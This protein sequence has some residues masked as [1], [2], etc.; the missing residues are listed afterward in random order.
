[1]NPRWS[2]VL[3][4]FAPGCAV[5]TTT[6]DTVPSGDYAEADADSDSDSDADSD[7]DVDTT[8]PPENEDALSL[9]PPAQT[10]RYV[11]VANPDRDTVTRIAV[12]TLD[13]DT[14]PVG[15]DPEIVLTTPDFQHAVVF[16]RGDATV[17]TI[18][19]NTLEKHTVDVRDNLNQMVMSPDGA[20]VVLF[21][22]VR[23]DALDDTGHEPDGL[24][25]FNEASFV[26]VATAAHSPMAVGFN[27]KMVRFTPDAR[28]AVVVSDA[29]LAKIELRREVL[30]PELF[31]LAPGELDAP[32]AEEVIVS[33]D[34][35]F[36]WVRQFGATELLVVDL[37]TGAVTPVPA[38]D[39]PTDLDLSPD[40][41]EAVAVARASAELWV[42]D[43]AR[44]FDAARVVGLPSGGSYG[45]LLFDPTGDQAVLYTTATPVER[46][47][48]WDRASDTVTERSLVKPVASMAITPTGGSVLVFHTR[49]DGP[50]TEPV[51]AGQ[52]AITLVDLDDF[53]SNPMLLPEDPIGFANA[54]S[55]LRGY[56]AMKNTLFLEVLDYVTLLNDQLP[57]FSVPAFVGVLPD[58]APADG[59]EPAAW[60]SQDHPL[61][62]ISFYDPD[63]GSLE[64]LTGFELNGGIDE[65][66]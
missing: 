9:L 54:E 8:L 46:F 66:P 40:G 51:F 32:S 59:D 16:S 35:S 57:L 3:L 37:E 60:V 56:F 21:H 30:A 47:A 5:P 11:F 27:P 41:A 4:T 42:Y 15:A 28:T 10:D 50:D 12:D 6:T 43:A 20:W 13:V 31:E 38:G 7:A 25:S 17:T 58:L 52:P 19:A 2:V 39:N 65:D 53:R 64:T 34:G 63:D 45:S 26:E 48:V 29:Y 22:D 23:L 61:G 1:M 18:D 36:A 55:G 44:P 62:R 14:T 33:A 24:Q 49:T